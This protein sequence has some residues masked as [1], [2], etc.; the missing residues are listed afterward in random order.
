MTALSARLR[1]L[2]AELPGW[3]CW[4]QHTGS[5]MGWFASRPFAG[6]IVEV[7]CGTPEGLVAAC[8]D[9]DRRIGA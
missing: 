8:G 6:A 7:R 5:T 1:E 4:A 9:F 3:K 2:M